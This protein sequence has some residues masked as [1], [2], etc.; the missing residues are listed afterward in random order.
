MRTEHPKCRERS[1]ALSLSLSQVFRTVV[2]LF[3]SPVFPDWGPID[4]SVPLHM[5][6]ERERKGKKEKKEKRKE[7]KID[8]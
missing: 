2:H 3:L 7:G 8:R 6:G 4:V 5:P 1:L